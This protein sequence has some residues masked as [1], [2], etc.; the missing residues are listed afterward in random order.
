MADQLKFNRA[1]REVPYSE[2]A[3]D[4]WTPL[5]EIGN[6]KIYAEPTKNKGSLIFNNKSPINA[7]RTLAR[8]SRSVNYMG[9]NYAFYEQV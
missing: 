5:E 7:L 4:V 3:Q 2:I 8:T 9:A 1:Y 6:K